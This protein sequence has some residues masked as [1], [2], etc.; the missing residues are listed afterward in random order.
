[1][2][3]LHF[4]LILGLLLIL[5]IYVYLNYNYNCNYHDYYAE[6]NNKKD[7]YNDKR[8]NKINYPLW[9]HNKYGSCNAT[10]CND[11]SIVTVPSGNMSFAKTDSNQNISA[12]YLNN[13]PLFCA[14][15]KNAWKK[16]CPNYWLFPEIIN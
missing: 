6:Y 2:N 1:M 3:E 8:D 9:L 4:A 10:G 15:A 13:P 14:D 16:P 5:A 11:H 7:V 12:E